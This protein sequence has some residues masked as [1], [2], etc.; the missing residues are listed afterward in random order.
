MRT[1]LSGHKLSQVF[2]NY[3][4]DILFEPF[5]DAMHFAVIAAGFIPVCAQDLSI[6][7]RPRL[8]MLMDAIT[9]CR[10]SAHDFSRSKGQGDHNFARLNMPIEMGMAL[11]HALQTQRREHYCAFFVSTPY[12]YQAV[13][14]DLAGLDPKCYNNDELQLM[15]RVYEWLRDVGRPLVNELS[16]VEVRREYERFK[17]E[18][19]RL[20]GSGRDGYPD[21]NEAQ[22]LMYQV[23]EKCG[24]WDIRATKAGMMEFKPLPLSWK[25]Q[26]SLANL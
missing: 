4:F 5:A 23:C 6:P 20:N 13:A 25:D 3:P 9:N 14:S 8:D 12:D 16:T 22:E 19:K 1:D 21:H 2:L 24:W 15:A 17:E 18:A 10:Y 11:F 7:D 26:T